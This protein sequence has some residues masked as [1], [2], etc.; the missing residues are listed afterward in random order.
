MLIYNSKKHI[1]SNLNLNDNTNFF[2]KIIN[3]T[4]SNFFLDCIYSFKLQLYQIYI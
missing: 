2:D 3:Y 1:T 4:S